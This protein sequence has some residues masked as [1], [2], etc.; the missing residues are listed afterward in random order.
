MGGYLFAQARIIG[1]WVSDDA[2]TAGALLASA[3]TLAFDGPPVVY[4]PEPNMAAAAVFDRFGFRAQPE[5]LRMR[6]GGTAPVGRSG[7]LYGLAALAIG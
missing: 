6:R 7:C 3:L 1:P 4:A 2:G 5:S